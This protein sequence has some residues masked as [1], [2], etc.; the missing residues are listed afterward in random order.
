MGDYLQ[1]KT[2]LIILFSIFLSNALCASELEWVDEQIEAIKPPRKSP[3]I[4]KV[5]DPFVFLE[6]NKPEVKKDAKAQMGGRVA[7]PLAK[8]SAI[9]ASKQE[10]K[11]KEKS[12][13]FNLSAIIN[14]SALIDG[15]W[16]KKSDKISSF[17]IAEISKKTVTLKKGDKEL[18]LSTISKKPNLKFKNK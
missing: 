9:L 17:I 18:I 8:P 15:S 16:Y 4:S 12:S 14:T 13:D 3:N 1:M 7:A 10:E 5:G 2:A 6:K 11:K